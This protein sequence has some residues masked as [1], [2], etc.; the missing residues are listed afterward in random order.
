MKQYPIPSLDSIPGD[1][2]MPEGPLQ[3]PHCWM[4]ADHQTSTDW[5]YRLTE[6]DLVELDAAL[7]HVNEAG[8]D[9]IEIEK[10][11]FP[12]GKL[13]AK[14][15]GLRHDILEGRGFVQIK[16]VPVKSKSRRDAAILYWG[17]GLH[18]GYLVPQNARG[19]L[20]GHV[21]N[22]GPV[23]EDARHVEADL[24]QRTF[25][26][27]TRRFPFHVDSGD[28]VGLMCMHG[29]RQGGE[30]LIASSAAIH[31]E[32]MRTRPDLLKVLYKPYWRDRRGGEIPTGAK[33]YFPMPVYCYHNGRLFA[34]YG[35]SNIR[36]GG[37][38]TTHEG[39]P[40]M[41]AEQHEAIMLL[42]KLAED[43]RFHLSMELEAG[44]IQLLNNHHIMHARTEYRDY[45]ELDRRRHL[46]RLWMVVPEHHPLP[47]WH[48]NWWGEGRR[49]GI[50]M[51]GMVEVAQW[52]P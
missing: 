30:S 2:T 12:L 16:G 32:I 20:L 27:N 48:Y 10:M 9:L 51:P 24:A 37:S 11:D 46:M 26:Q 47:E 7:A 5:Q 3:G 4:S 34:P 49:G 40:A 21:V 38:G 36:S 31:N 42:E 22:L 39:L 25:D 1:Y 19:Q 18:L 52:D 35:S 33:P 44:D 23:Q 17:I 8:L 50:Y 14:L 15:K 13:A 43:P 41:T 28:I 45:P 29:A 6:E